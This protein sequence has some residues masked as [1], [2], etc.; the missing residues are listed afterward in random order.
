MRTTDKQAEKIIQDFQ[1]QGDFSSDDDFEYAEAMHYLIDKYHDPDYMLDL[2]A[3][4]YEQKNFDLALKYYEMAAAAG[5]VQAEE[6]LGYI[7]YYGRTGQRDYRQAFKYFSDAADHG[8]LSSQYKV[9]DMYKNGF[10]VDR[11]M[12]RYRDIIVKLRNDR[13]IAAPSVDIYDP[14]P[15]VFI[16]YG[17]LIQDGLVNEDPDYE[18]TEESRN[19]VS[20]DFY[21][22]AR[23]ILKIRLQHDPFFGDLSMM[24]W[25]TADI[26]KLFHYDEPED[27]YDLYYFLLKPS[28]YR[29]TYNHSDH[30][31]EAVEEDGRISIRFDDSWFRELTDFFMKAEIEGERITAIA[32]DIGIERVV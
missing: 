22:N 24:R 9:A 13:R 1:N 15:E 8:S 18:I 17:H 5:S 23:E 28:E 6:N 2:G 7:W 26:N 32:D 20:A 19:A 4:Y 29:L 11:D 30:E 3:H 27:I 21:E 10:Y 16:R 25:M 12:H 31:I 14:V